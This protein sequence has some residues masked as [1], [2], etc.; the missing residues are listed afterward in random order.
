[1]PYLFSSCRVCSGVQYVSVQNAQPSTR[2]RCGKDEKLP[3]GGWTVKS[4]F[5]ILFRSL[6][7]PLRPL[8]AHFS[9]PDL[10]YVIASDSR[11]RC[12]VQTKLFRAEKKLRKIK[13][14]QRRRF[15]LPSVQFDGGF[16][17]GERARPSAEHRI[18]LKFFWFFFSQSTTERHSGTYATGFRGLLRFVRNLLLLTRILTSFPLLS[19]I[20]RVIETPGD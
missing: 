4:P 19:S 14:L 11:L 6:I 15:A 17:E 7:P 13:N 1:M 20:E 12:T 10:A 8:L 2:K 3:F 18:C 5:G 16:S 9:P